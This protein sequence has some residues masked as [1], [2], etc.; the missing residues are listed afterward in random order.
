MDTPLQTMIRQFNVSL[1]NMKVYA[2]DH[3]SMA[4]ALQKAHEAIIQILDERGELSLAVVQNKLLVNESPI[5]DDNQLVGR[6][7][8]ELTLRNVQSLTF[9][10]GLSMDE[11]KVF[12]GCMQ[13]DPD[14]LSMEGGVG[15]F[16]E[17]QGVLN[18]VANDV[19]YGK[20]NE[21][22]EE[23][24]GWRKRSLLPS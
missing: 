9:R 1:R 2:V 20:I 16:L 11:F 4:R 22:M 14:R 13:Q 5:E 6:L 12:L 15:Q 18:V 19:K 23:G 8:E 10:N 24:E 7:V 21:G 17:K 3:P